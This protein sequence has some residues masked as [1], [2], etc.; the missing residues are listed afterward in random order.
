MYLFSCLFIPNNSTISSW[1]N[2]FWVDRTQ[3]Y[4]E[5]AD[6]GSIS[7]QWLKHLIYV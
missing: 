4:C 7:E 5:F 6:L 1:Q 3:Q 2:K